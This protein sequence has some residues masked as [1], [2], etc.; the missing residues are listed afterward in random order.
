MNFLKEYNVRTE[1][2]INNAALK[3][4]LENKNVNATCIYFGTFKDVDSHLSLPS[5]ELGLNEKRMLQDYK[6]AFGFLYCRHNCGLC[7]T[8]CS[9]NVPVNTIMRYNHYFFSQD[10]QK[11]AMALYNDL[12][13]KK[14]DICADCGG[15]CEKH[16]PF[17]VPVQ[18]LLNIAHQNLTLV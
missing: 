8:S 4:T 17:G 10:R 2:D 16:C 5:L 11:E 9:H 14:A 3:F 6:K 18:G 15:I 1:D 12:N 13:T 7:E